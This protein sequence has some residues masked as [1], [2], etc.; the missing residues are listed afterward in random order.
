[1]PPMPK[2]SSQ[3][4]QPNRRKPTRIPVVGEVVIPEL[5]IEDPHPR[6][7]GLWEAQHRSAQSV[8]MEESDWQHFSLAMELLDRQ[9]K[10]S[11]LNANLIQTIESMLGSHGMSEGHRRRLRI[12]VERQTEKIADVVDVAD[13]FRRMMG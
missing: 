7:R 6:V 5:T 9:L 3:T 13:K 8:Y 10:G 4:T 2:R 11:R 12:E 1:M